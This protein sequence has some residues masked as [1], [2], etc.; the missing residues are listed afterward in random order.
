MDLLK[1]KT[2]QNF[3]DNVSINQDLND[4]ST[5]IRYISTASKSIA[6]KIKRASL[7]NL[8]GSTSITNLHGEEV[9]TLDA[10]SNTI[11][12]ETLKN[13]KNICGLVSEEDYDVIR[14]NKDGKY[15]VTF[16]PLDG[17][18]NID[19]NVNIGTI[20]GIFSRQSEIGTSVEEFDCLQPGKNLMCSGYFLYGTSTIFVLA[21]NDRVI[22]FTLD[23]NIGEFML[24][25][26]NLRIPDEPK[27]YSLNEGYYNKWDDNLREF[28]DYLKS[29]DDKNNKKAFSSRYIGSMV[30]DVHRTLLYGGIFLYPGTKTM[31]SGKLRYLYEV[32]PM[33]YIIEMAGG[34]SSY[35]TNLESKEFENSALNLI[36][37]SIHQRVPVI[38]GSPKYIDLINS[39]LK[40][41]E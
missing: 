4:L 38:L 16:D 29:D 37:T 34:K 28:V 9:K 30:A 41:K 39:F 36:P 14:L 27:I 25:H 24:T 40:I 6:S 20:F 2:L 7:E 11:M 1:L 33:S 19:V 23:E 18:S 10:L 17:S 8:I 22:G 21:L 3:L 12:I 26:D 35:D 32:A 5:I 13:C 31:K 15:I